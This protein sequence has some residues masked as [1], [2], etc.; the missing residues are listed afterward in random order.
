MHDDIIPHCVVGFVV[1]ASP[2]RCIFIDSNCISLKH[3]METNQSFAT[4]DEDQWPS[5]P[6]SSCT[7]TRFSRDEN[8]IDQDSVI[9]TKTTAVA[10]P[11]SSDHAEI[12]N[13]CDEDKKGWTKSLDEWPN[14]T[15]Q[16][17]ARK[18]IDGSKTMPDSSKAPKAYRNKK[19][20]YR[21]WREGYV[22]HIYVKPN[23][24]ANNKLFI[25]KGKV[26][27][28]MKKANYLVYVHLEQHGGEVLY[29]KCECK[30][31][32]GGCCKHVA[33]LLYTLLD[34]VN[35]GA[36]EVPE[37]M[38]CTQVAQK[39]HVPSQCNTTLKKAVKFHDLTFEK[40]D[41]CKKPKRCVFD[42][43]ESFCATPQYAYSTDSAE[44][45]GFV[46]NLCS[47]GSAD[48]FCKSLAS[49][50][51]EPCK[52]FETSCTKKLRQTMLGTNVGDQNCPKEVLDIRKIFRKM[53]NEMDQVFKATDQLG[54]IKALVGVVKNSAADICVQTVQQSSS[55]KWYA[56]RS[57]RIITSSLFGNIKNI[58]KK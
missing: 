26:H 3:S 50:Q 14:I 31:G 30:A 56:E 57:Q 45:K 49:N 48:L 13:L 20:G 27:A 11:K 54:N 44:L 51:F 29:A 32:Q 15:S 34:F 21:L 17:I 7:I 25:V 40:A 4:N 47:I 2:L 52:L 58:E 8:A 24:Q 19:L 37:E 39:W 5:F 12:K 33:A 35:S 28:S 43:S 1:T 16:H 53:N 46:E 36:R 6:K 18:L 10:R 38:T 9:G 41:E 23:V 22:R 55:N 42:A